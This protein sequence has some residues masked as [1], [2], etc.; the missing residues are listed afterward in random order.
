ME[1]TTPEPMERIGP[2]EPVEST[3]LADR[4]DRRE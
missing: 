4:I 2:F 1:R 3:D